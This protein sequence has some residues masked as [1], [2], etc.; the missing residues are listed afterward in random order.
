MKIIVTDEV[1]QEG[2]ALL[3]QD[4]RV[5]INIKLGL[6]KEELLA[7]IGN[8]DAIITRSGTTVDKN[9]LDAG[10]KLRLIA[11]AGVGIDNVDVDY[12]SSRGV[13]VVNAPFGNT[14][15]AAEHA[16]ALLLSFC[17]NVP[18][19]NG[20]LKSGEWKRAPFTGYELKGKTAGVIGLGKVGGRVATRL[21]AFECEVLA[22]DPYI[23]VK[24]AHDLGVKLVSHDEIYRNCDIITV[25]TPLTDETRN[26]IGER[27]LAMMKDGVIIVNAARGGIIEE[28]ALLKYLESGKITGAAIDVF[29]VEPPKTDVLQKLI[30]HE[31]VIVTPHL[32]ANT[33]EAQVNVAVDVSKEILNY[34]DDLPLENAVNIPR[35]DLALMDQMRPFLN[36]MSVMSD[37]VIQLVD[38]NIDTV[39]FSYAGNIAHYDCTPLSVCGLSSILNRL[40]E[41]DVN[42]VNAT[43][44]ADQMGITV[45]ENKSTQSPSFSNMI[46]LTIEGKGEK[47]TIAGTLFEG[48]PRIVKLRDYQVDFAPDEHMLS[49]TYEDRPGMI[50]KIGTI[51]GAHDINIASMNLGRREKRGEAM[52]ILSLDSAVPPFV[53]EEVRKATDATFIKPIHMPGV[54]CS[55][56]CGCGI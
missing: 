16:M 9:L 32:G 40:V 56:G 39:T 5:E 44:I 24:R 38:A 34:L 33:F 30:A 28:E 55:R 21:K 41:Q 3:A 48:S 51:M 25:H 23:A 22:C 10:T 1:A 37:F 54:K 13:I 43:L 36:L 49:L 47:R 42:M 45:E 46:T 31:R 27:E 29:S 20:S 52:V 2:L 18:R 15:S 11:R 14:N 17:R 12:A 26:M 50:G 53:V 6:K 8:Y 19:A 35:F 4:P 7:I